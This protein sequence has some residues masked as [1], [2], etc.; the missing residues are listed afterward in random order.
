MED[1]TG[2]V[3]GMGVAFDRRL[4]LEFHGAT[5][6]SDAGLLAFRELDDALGLTRLATDVLVDART[7]EEWPPHVACP[8]ASVGVRPPP[9]CDV[10][11]RRPLV[12]PG[13][14]PTRQKSLAR[15]SQ[16]ALCVARTGP[17]PDH[18][19]NVGS[20]PYACRRTKQVL[21]WCL[22]T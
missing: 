7:G 22:S 19:G 12:V 10:D 13:P 14:G 15:R 21:V 16:L 20:K 9:W 4:K 5:V 17:Q 18:L 2:D 8:V 6:T 11:P 3:D 1:A